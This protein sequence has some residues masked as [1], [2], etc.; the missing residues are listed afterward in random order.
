MLA[1]A[2]PAMKQPRRPR[3]LPP[4]DALDSDEFVERGDSDHPP[5]AAADDWTDFDP[6]AGDAWDPDLFEEPEETLP[7]HGDFFLEPEEDL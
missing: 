4:H 6:A 7:E 3:P 2:I 5:D 1:A